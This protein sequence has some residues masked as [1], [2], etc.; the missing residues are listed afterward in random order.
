MSYFQRIGTGNLKLV[1]LESRRCVTK[2][3]ACACSLPR[4]YRCPHYRAGLYYSCHQCLNIKLSDF[5]ELG[6]KDI[7]INDL[8][9]DLILIQITF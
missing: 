5:S 6:E 1:M 4:Y 8:I 3:C 7:L 9:D 2:A